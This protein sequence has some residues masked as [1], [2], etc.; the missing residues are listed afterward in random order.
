MQTLKRWEEQERQRR[1][2]LRDS[3]RTSMSKT[4]LVEDVSRRAS[5]LWNESTQR[6]TSFRRGARRIRDMDT[7]FEDS[8]SRRT[9]EGTAQTHGGSLAPAT[10]SRRDTGRSASPS[11]PTPLVSNNPFNTPRVG[12][13]ASFQ[14]EDRPSSANERDVFME[15]SSNPPT[16]F[17]DSHVDPEFPDRPI[18]QASNSYSLDTLGNDK[19]STIGHPPPKS[20][21]LP[22]GAAPPKQMERTSSPVVLPR[23]EAELADDDEIEAREREQGRW[24]T[25]WLC[26]CRENSQ[27]QVSLF[28]SFCLLPIW[29]T[30]DLIRRRA[31]QTHSNE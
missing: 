20:L 13:P 1:R 22:A 26:G 15:E 12:S 27:E 28:F 2:A 10:P 4:S 5:K 17:N 23:N 18:L 3:N 29:L 31:R 7:S 24:W 19:K 21:D 8:P 30:N 25:D 14:L 16:P 6:R 11:S 9:S